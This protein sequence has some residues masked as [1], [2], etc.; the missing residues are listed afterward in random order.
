MAL[1]VGVILLVTS[2]LLIFL[3]VP[4]SISIA[5]S[6]IITML[7]IFPFDVTIFTAAQKMVT[8]LDIFSLLAIPFFVLSGIIMNSGGIALR[9]IN[10]AKLLSG[11]LPGS[12]AHT[13][14][15]GN[16]LFGAISGSSTASAA[17][18][19]RVMT[20]LQEKEGY[21]RAYSA[22]VNIA[23]SG[24]GMIIPPSS[25]MIIYSLVSGGTSIA[26]LFMAGYIPG[27]LWGLSLILV[28]YFI[29]KKNNYPIASKV[30][31][32]E[33]FK[34]FLDAIPSLLLVIIVLGGITAGVFTATEGAAIAV[35]YAWF[36]SVC[37]KNFQIKQLPKML[38]ETV[39]IT[40]VI[41]LMIGTSAVL[42]IVLTFA[43]IP[44]A[45]TDGILQITDNPILVLLIIN[46][47]LIIVGTGMDV[48]PA[49]LIFTPILLPVVEN[50]GM[51]PVH[52]G[53]VM[54]FNLCIGSITPPVGSPLFVGCKVAKVEI[55]EVIKPLMPFYASIFVILLLVTYFPQISLF[56]PRFFN[57]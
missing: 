46:L 1:E 56:L 5:A 49:I 15:F 12:L 47:I 19:G 10:F 45:I 48:T 54:V 55:E 38:I 3:G 27:I 52:F 29:A 43:G 39:E 21:N 22:A 2:F 35:A 20:P 53:I 34:V 44:S 14:I 16:M 9:L 36:L 42:S 26:A 7:V 13:N 33:K 4:I 57:L 23:S 28:A 41:M 18:I 8:G 31:F 6:S 40:A 17:A 50:I 25:L 32:S 37:Y 11:R 24:T 30:K 51:D